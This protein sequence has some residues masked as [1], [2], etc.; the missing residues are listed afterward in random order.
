MQTLSPS[1][2]ADR[3]VDENDPAS[4][5]EQTF[6]RLQT[7]GEAQGRDNNAQKLLK[8][9]VSRRHFIFFPLLLAYLLLAFPEGVCY[10]YR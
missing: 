3:S 4:S 1:D 9:V 10:N 2:E 6:Y 8:S 7:T 5:E